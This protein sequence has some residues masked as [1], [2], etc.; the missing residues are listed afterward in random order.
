MR[1][2]LSNTSSLRAAA[3]VA[4]TQAAEEA[5]GAFEQQLGLR[6]LP[7]RLSRSRWAQGVPG[8]LQMVLVAATAVTPY[9]VRSLQRAAAV[10]AEMRLYPMKALT[11]AL[12]V[13]V[14][15]MA[16]VRWVEPGQAGRG[17]TA[18]R[19]S[20]LSGPALVAA[21]AHLLWGR[22]AQTTR[23]GMA[24]RVRHRALPAHLSTIP[25]VAA[26]AQR[27]GRVGLPH[28][29][30]G[31]VLLEATRRQQ[32]PRI[33]EVVVVVVVLV[34]LRKTARMEGQGLSR[35]ATPIPTTRRLRQPDRQLTPL[36][37][38]IESTHGPAAVPLRSEVGDGSFCRNR[39]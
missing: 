26:V 8:R 23:A 9:S 36:P 7:E 13:A 25:A 3:V 37:A 10:A 20:T 27:R 2:P 32:A 31:R 34:A 30:A 24:V 16:R 11:A 33:R 22:T 5:L 6:F 15:G 38:G 18:D 17:I 19:A 14:E 12:A 1:L 21:V 35:S 28:S 29:V 4:V 39:R